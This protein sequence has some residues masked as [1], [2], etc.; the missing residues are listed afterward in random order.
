MKKVCLFAFVLLPCL[1]L[2]GLAQTTPPV[3]VGDGGGSAELRVVGSDATGVSFEAVVEEVRATVVDRA[4]G[5]FLRLALPGGASDE[6][7]SPDLPVLRTIVEVPFGARDFQV[8]LGSADWSEIELAEI[9][10]ADRVWPVQ[11]PAVK[12]EI[13]EAPLALD[14]TEYA[15]DAFA[16]AT[17][18]VVREAGI[19]RGHRLLVISFQPVRY[20]PVRAT[21]EICARAKFDVTFTGADWAATERIQQRLAS[22]HFD[23]I[24]DTTVANRGFLESPKA[25]PALPIGYLIITHTN[26][27]AGIQPLAQW[28]STIGYDVTVANTT[29]TGTTT[30]QIKNYIQTAY[31]TWPVP[32]TY[33]LLVGDSNYIPGYQGSSTSSITDLYYTTMDGGNYFP[34]IMIGRLSVANTTQL[35][36]VVGKLLDY[37]QVAFPSTAWIK[38]AAFLASTDNHTISEGTHNYVI[39]NFLN[40]AGYTCD[41]LYTYTYGATTQDVKNSLNNG[42]SLA[43]YSGHGYETGWSDGPPFNQSDV[44]SLVNTDMYPFV[45]SHACLTGDFETSEC[46]SETWIR[47]PGKGGLIF[48]GSS[49]YTYWDEDDV[50]EKKMFEA[51]FSG[52]TWHLAGMTN[53]ALLDLYAHYGG[54][55]LS[56][57]YFECYIVQGDP[58]IFLHTEVPVLPTVTHDD[59]VTVGAAQVNVTVQRGATPVAN[60]LVHL[61]KSGEVFETVYTNASGQAM[62]P[63][64]TTTPGFIDITVTGH[65]L[66]PYQDQIVVIV[67]EGAYVVL[68]DQLI[69]DTTGGN[70]DGNIDVGEAI[71]LQVAGKNVG[72]ATA[73]GV[74]ATLSTSDPMITI[75]DGSETFGD[76]DPAEVVWCADDFDFTVDTMCEDGHVAPLTVNFFDTDSGDWSYVLNVQVNAPKMLFDTF[77]LDDGA[78]NGDG[79]ADPG[80]TVQFDVCLTNDGHHV[81]ES[82]SV[83]LH[84][85]DGYCTVTQAT[86]AYPN[87]QPG[88]TGWNLTPFVIEVSPSCPVGHSVLVNVD[89][90]REGNLVDTDQFTFVVSKIPVLLIDLDTTHNSAP[91]IEAALTA[92]GVNYTKTLSWPTNFD[93]HA[94]LFIC[95]GIYS[96]NTVLSTTQANQ[97]VAFLQNG[98]NVYMEGGDCW[99]YDS[100]ADVYAPYFGI[101]PLSDGSGDTSTVVGQ[102]GTIAEGMSFAYT[103]DNNWMD[104]ISN[105]TGAKLIFRNQSP[106]YGN[107]VSFDTGTYRT[108]GVTFE[109][110]GLA[111]GA[112]GTKLEWM[113]KMVN[114]LVA[115]EPPAWILARRGTVNMASGT[116]ANVLFLNGS[117]GN[118]DRIVYA[119]TGASLT[120][121]MSAPPAGPNPAPFAM[122]LWIGEPGAGNLSPQPKNLGSAVFGTFLASSDGTVP[123]KVWNNI[124]RYS[125]LG[126]PDFPSTP[127]PSTFLQKGSGL[128]NP[129]TLTFQGIVLDNGSAADKPASL[130]NAVILKIQ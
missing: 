63:V 127:A 89:V 84:T 67:P 6:I 3:V 115:P 4:E 35:A 45:M 38:K 129:I 30:T 20:N 52:Q 42:R 97:V 55:G 7:G 50:L 70:G 112:G 54:G 69:G 36:T 51:A 126:T 86:S 87:I 102:T 103:G 17:T 75:T 1:G 128:G 19:L 43:V 109:F 125:L 72:I 12:L 13:G 18:V 26:F 16:P 44:N 62:I 79:I 83:T 76:I 9:S 37:E 113:Q 48:W 60:A 71:D 49:T 23:E 95:L 104:Q 78:G 81:G 110:G 33:V 2:I 28:K 77:T 53:Q 25:V 94:N 96:D 31:N 58:S 22:P 91:A 117:A 121:T 114:F 10:D 107:G 56:Q 119:A 8:D 82:V 27:E 130:T 73:P 124:G 92:L 85:S 15:K 66:I 21:L 34:D 14:P 47:A 108:V 29:V 93:L 122:Y 24:L 46:F 74:T 106:N 118:A 68:H 101:N 32:P 90:Y 65:N 39:S 57:Y 120:G 100:N 11:P 116:P 5:R 123:F 80:E 41:K 61:A 88:L 111:D 105:L 40:P 64:S 98:G 59:A 99:Y